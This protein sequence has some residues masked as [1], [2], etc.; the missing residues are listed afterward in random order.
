ME[1]FGIPID[2]AM[3]IVLVERG[4]RPACTVPWDFP[5]TAYKHRNTRFTKIRIESNQPCVFV[6]YGK[7]V[8]VP[9]SLLKFQEWND[10]TDY[11]IVG[12]FLG[13]HNGHVSNSL[14]CKDIILSVS[15]HATELEE[16]ESRIVA[17][18]PS[19][20]DH[21]HAELA[22]MMQ[23]ALGTPVVMQVKWERLC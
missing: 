8:Q 20:V 21:K 23:K 22:F 10:D 5:M 7:D 14:Q 18:E 4:V 11:D 16:K 3:N 12:K 13:Y 19:H 2:D 9:R 17:W 15:F 1:K 6:V